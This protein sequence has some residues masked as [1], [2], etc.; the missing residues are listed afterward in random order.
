MPLYVG[1]DVHLKTCYATAMNERG[2]ILKQE[3]FANE[4]L[5]IERFFRG[6]DDAKVAIEASYSWMPVYELLEGKGY[7]VKL[8]HP[9]ETRIIAKAKVKTDKVDSERLAHLLRSNLLPTSYVPPKEIRELRDL[10]RLRTYLV[11]ERTRFKNKIRAELA[12]RGIHVFRNPFT[13]KGS[14]SLKGLEIKSVDSCLAI[15]SALDARIRE[16][17]AEIERKAVENEDAKL[18]MSIP[19]VGC[20][21]ALAIVA[22]I[23]DVSRFP[24]EEKLCSYAGLA[25]YVDQSGSTARYGPITKQG[26]KLLRWIIFE[27]LWAHIRLCPDSRISRFFFRLAAIK[28]KQIAATAAARKLLVAIYWMLRN[29]EE[30]RVN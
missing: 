9:K 10:V 2:E 12:K 29:R 21:S 1:L 11:V 19:G 30:F 28:G 23:G 25:P 13:R 17:S 3:K 14:S 27:C 4:G 5:E 24:D 22:E 15:I 8:A 7:E 20:F 16:L 26:S 18:L 6:I